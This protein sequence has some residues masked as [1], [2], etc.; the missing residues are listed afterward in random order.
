[1]TL[2]ITTGTTPTTYDPTGTVSCLRMAVFLSRAR[3]RAQP[4][5]VRAA[6]GSTS[7]SH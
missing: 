2:G 5:M 7:G 6:T 4:L 3:V 1:M